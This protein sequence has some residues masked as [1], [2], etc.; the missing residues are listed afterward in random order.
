[1]TRYVVCTYVFK[2]IASLGTDSCPSDSDQSLLQNPVE[3]RGLRD[4]PALQTSFGDERSDG[5]LGYEAVREA[6]QKT[7]SVELQFRPIPVVVAVVGW[8]GLFPGM[9]RGG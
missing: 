4:R 5:Q 8:I 7:R 9:K 2:C 1:M 3:I 6:E